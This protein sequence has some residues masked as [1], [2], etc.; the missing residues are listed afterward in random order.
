MVFA[1]IVAAPAAHGRAPPDIVN[2]TTFMVQGH[3]G[4]VVR[5]ARLEHL[6]ENCPAS[7]AVR[8]SRLGD[9]A[10]FVEVEAVAAKRIA[11]AAA[12]GAAY[13]LD[14]DGPWS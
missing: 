8:V 11:R 2:L 13:S 4:K 14:G 9:P 6:G 12:S 1:N 5:N 3:D 7:A 10:W